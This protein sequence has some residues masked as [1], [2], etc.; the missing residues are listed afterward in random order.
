MLDHIN[1]TPLPE[2][3]NGLQEL[4][5]KPLISAVESFTENEGSTFVSEQVFLDH[6]QQLNAV[7][8]D[9]ANNVAG[10]RESIAMQ[11]GKLNSL[12]DEQ[13]DK[14]NR[15]DREIEDI[16]ARQKEAA[17]LQVIIE[18]MQPSLDE[19]RVRLK[20]REVALNLATGTCSNIYNHFNQIISKYTANVM[21]K[22]TEGRYKQIQIDDDLKVRVFATEKNDFAV[23]DELSSGTQRQIMLAVRLAISKALVEAGQHGKQFI[24]LDEPFAFFDRERIRNTI[25]SLASIDKNITQIWIL[26][27]EF[28]SQE[29]FELVIDCT[30]DQDNLT[31]AGGVN[32]DSQVKEDD[33]VA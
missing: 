8:D 30:R 18:D 24:I 25:K 27:Q 5:S 16:H 14:I 31:L 17:D 19:G 20:V 11:I 21:P 1:D 28:E 13:H 33:D 15:L 26:T 7:L 32:T 22:L 23:L 9:N 29:N 4:D 2:L 10:L 12:T 3:M 6:Q